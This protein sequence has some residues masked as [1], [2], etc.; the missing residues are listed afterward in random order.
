MSMSWYKMNTWK[1]GSNEK[2]KQTYGQHRLGNNDYDQLS[3]L[4]RDT[5]REKMKKLKREIKFLERGMHRVRLRHNGIQQDPILT[6]P[7]SWT[8]IILKHLIRSEYQ[9]YS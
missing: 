2:R 1:L 5:K 3:Q 8:C 7:M 4:Y 6:P 9:H